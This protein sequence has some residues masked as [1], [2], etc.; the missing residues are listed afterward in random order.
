MVALRWAALPPADVRHAGVFPCRTRHGAAPWVTFL[1]V[2]WLPVV[3]C[4]FVVLH[5]GVFREIV[6]WL[7]ALRTAELQGPFPHTEELRA[8]FPKVLWFPVVSQPPVVLR[9]T[10]ARVVVAGAAE[11]Q[12][13]SLPAARLR[14]ALPRVAWFEVLVYRFVVLQFAVFRGIA[15]QAV[16]ARVATLQIPELQVVFLPVAW[17]QVASSRVAWL[18]VMAHRPVVPQIV[19]FQVAVLPAALSLG[20]GAPCYGVQ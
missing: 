9:E 8:V 13:V 5:I 3:V 14:A 15:P 19:A 2:A 18:P 7:A 11:P 17:Q 6:P 1:R 4:R 16:V 12:V 10:V 20:D